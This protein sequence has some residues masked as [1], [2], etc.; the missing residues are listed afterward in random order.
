MSKK[1]RPFF[2]CK[3]FLR[4]DEICLSKGIDYDLQV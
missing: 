1:T 3:V 2:T 4:D